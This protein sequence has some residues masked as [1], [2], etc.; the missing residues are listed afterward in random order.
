[1][2]CL[3]K[4]LA[5]LS[6]TFA[7]YGS[8]SVR[9]DFSEQIFTRDIFQW[10][11]VLLCKSIVSMCY[12]PSVSWFCSGE[13]PVIPRLYFF[14]NNVYFILGLNEISHFHISVRH[15]SRLV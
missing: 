14:I 1:M 2:I 5:M 10:H 13:L 8:S 9:H 4:Y 7:Q 15:P 6:Y 11:I 12:S 3:R